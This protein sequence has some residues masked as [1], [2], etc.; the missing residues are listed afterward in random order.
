ML[1]RLLEARELDGATAK[2][3]HEC[4]RSGGYGVPHLWLSATD[5]VTDVS[6][7]TV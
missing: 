1:T 7:K 5:S 6:Y 4:L 3:V 2:V